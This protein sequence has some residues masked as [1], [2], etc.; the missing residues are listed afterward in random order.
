MT[1]VDNTGQQHGP[2]ELPLE[3]EALLKG[4]RGVFSS[5]SAVRL[6]LTCMLHVL[7]VCST[8]ER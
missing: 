8:A 7:F 5:S 3:A 4:E 1:T 6:L 2:L